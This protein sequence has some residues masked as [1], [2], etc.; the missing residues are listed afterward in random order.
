MP[1]RQWF[2]NLAF[3]ALLGACFFLAISL[4]SSSIAGG[5]DAYRHVR[6]ANRLATQTRSALA[7]PWRLAYLWPKPVDVWFGYHALLAPLTLLLPLVSAAKL[8][9]AIAWAGGLFAI[10]QWLDRLGARWARAWVALAA[11]GSGIVLYRAMLVR[12]F[13]LSLLLMILAARYVTEER[14]IA[15]GIVSLLH[16]LS[17]SIFFL[18]LM[19]AG[20]Y[21]LIR[22]TGRS[23]ILIAACIA[24]LAL[25]ILASPFFPENLKFSLAQTISPFRTPGLDLD[26]GMEVRPINAVWLAVTLPVLVVWV[27]ALIAF[28]SRM[29][30]RA[31]LPVEWLLLAMS[32]LCFAVSFRASRML[33]LFVP[34]AILFAA[35]VLSPWIEANREKAA[36]GFGLLCLLSA[37]SFVPLAETL[38]AAP[39]IYGS[40]GAADFLAREAPDALVMNAN[41]GEYPFLYFWNWKSRYV[42]G[43]DPT[44]LYANNPRRYW[45]WRHLSDDALPT[46]G[47]Q[48]CS[49]AAPA[50]LEEAI[51]KEIGARY[52]FLEHARNPKLEAAL[53]A[54]AH[55][56][57]AYRDS[58]NSVFAIEDEGR[59]R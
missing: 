15:L 22:R 6:F 34:F 41:W 47:V 45:M 55:A 28:G 52:V 19:P 56:R 33:D 23:L 48:N 9:G 54:S 18:P 7:D 27:P 4:A 57:E 5:D 29:R 16:A 2:S 13:L 25:G 59:V 44:F 37:L 8:M 11:I 36:Y 30:R 20:L 50:D 26:I 31:V 1:R 40:R 38:R 46:C 10:L 21:L 35:L 12:P 24:G 32:I 42:T 43:I 39:S 3:A 53:R 51:T 17:Y 58:D 49:G 14:P